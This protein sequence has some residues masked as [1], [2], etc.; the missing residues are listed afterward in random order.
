[1]PVYCVLLLVVRHY[2]SVVWY[3]S[4]LFCA[5]Q[6]FFFSSLVCVLF[7][8]FFFFF[9]SRRRHTRWTGD[10]S[11]DVCS[12]D[13]GRV[14]LGDLAADAG[15]LSHCAR[16]VAHGRRPRPGLGRGGGVGAPDGA[17]GGHPR[18]EERRVGKECRS[19]RSPYHEIEKQ[20][21]ARTVVG[22]R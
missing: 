13:L 4:V 12:S 1:M 16:N 14:A 2:S 5:H 9:S 10:W 17:A 7:S 19:R 15:V 18:S 8:L 20:R 21:R 22:V 3:Y 6:S 11:S